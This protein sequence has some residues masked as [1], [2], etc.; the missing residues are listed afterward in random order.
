MYALALSSV[1][2]AA[3]IT[4][5]S[6]IAQNNT[7]TTTTDVFERSVTPEG[8]TDPKV[9]ANAPSPN[10][11]VKGEAKTAKYV[12]DIRNNTLYKYDPN[13]QP[14]KAYL[15]A[16]GMEYNRTKPG[17][18]RVSHIEKSPFKYAPSWTKRRKNPRAYGKYVVIL[19]I[20]DE[21]TGDLSSIGQFIHGNK[22]ETS[23][24]KKVSLGCMRMNNKVMNE[25]ISQET[26]RGDYVLLMNPDPDWQKTKKK[27]GK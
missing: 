9:L 5:Q 7:T 13:G 14:L 22:D 23:I 15:V 21:K 12:V 6:A 25:E 2:A 17:L 4:P 18:R 3:V 8:T 20:V 27:R 19:D 10:I 16:T 1:T 26:K 11:K 24:G